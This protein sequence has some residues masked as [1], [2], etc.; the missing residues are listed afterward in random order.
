[1]VNGLIQGIEVPEGDSTI[2]FK[3]QPISIYIGGAVSILTLAIALFVIIK[4]KRNAG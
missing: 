2:E 1:M 4:E 3:F